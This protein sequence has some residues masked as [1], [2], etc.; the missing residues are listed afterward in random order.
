[1]MIWLCDFSPPI[2]GINKKERGAGGAEGEREPPRSSIVWQTLVEGACWRAAG[3]NITEIWQGRFSKGVSKKIQ[4]TK[5]G[6]RQDTLLVIEMCTGFSKPLV[7]A[8]LRQA[9]CGAKSKLQ[10]PGHDGKGK[11]E[12]KTS[13]CQQGSWR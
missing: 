10:C 11:R 3:K 2:F 5:P 12:K 7:P 13:Q 1:M 6:H 4:S 9:L 8:L